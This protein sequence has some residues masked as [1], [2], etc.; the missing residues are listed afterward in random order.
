MLSV[1][2]TK[3]WAPKGHKM[4]LLPSDTC[5]ISSII[6]SYFI[7]KLKCKEVTRP[8]ACGNP[9]PWTILPVSLCLQVTCVLR[10]Q[11]ISLWRNARQTMAST[12]ASHQKNKHQEYTVPAQNPTGQNTP[13]QGDWLDS[14]T[15]KRTLQI[16]QI[17]PTPTPTP[18]T[19]P[20][21]PKCSLSF[22]HHTTG[23]YAKPG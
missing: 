16:T 13:W 8:E 14:P 18:T 5:F 2:G 7:L 15:V 12:V 10:S 21:E 4:P 6:V 23:F 11:V 22:S 19:A 3:V 1:V 17:P 20:W 9:T